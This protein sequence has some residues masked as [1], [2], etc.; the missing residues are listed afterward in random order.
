[1]TAA[2]L[3]VATVAAVGVL[4]TLVPDHWAPIVVIARQRRWSR[5]RTLQAAAI[6]G[7]GHVT[8][9][10]ALGVVLWAVGAVAAARYGH[11]VN[12]VAALALIAFGA[13]IAVAGWRELRGHGGTHH[14]HH[15]GGDHHHDH[16]HGDA[17]QRTTLL[18]ILGSSPMVEGL[19]AFLAASTYGAALLAA[20]AVV[21]A[22][23]TI[24]TYVAVTGVALR[25]LER[26]SLGPLERYGEVLS[27]LVVAAVGVFAL[28]TA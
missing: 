28:V 10:L 17:S 5:M 13:W 12:V 27:G 2:P 9:T 18:L 26:V 4:H 25:G 20:M 7:V 19:P 3:L 22:L 14:H 6:A 1:V 24:V 15:D 8:S 11:V 23:A 16:A 21:F